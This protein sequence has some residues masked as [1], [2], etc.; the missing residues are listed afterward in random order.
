MRPLLFGLAAVAAVA[1]IASAADL[2]RKVPAYSPSVPVAFNW[3]GFYIGLNAGG[4]WGRDELTTSASVPNFGD[5][6][7][8]NWNAAAA[9]ANTPAGFIGGLELGY[10]WQ[11]NGVVLGLEG[12]VNGLTGK[13]T[14]AVV[15]PG[16]SPAAGDSFTTSAESNFLA[17]VRGRLGLALDRWLAYGTGGMAIGIV[18]TTDAALVDCGVACTPEAVSQTTTRIGWTAGGG[19]EYAFIP[20][21]TAKIEYLYVHLGDF[22]TAIP[23]LVA[24][25]DAGP[26]I[27]V[28]HK[29]TDNIVRVGANYKFW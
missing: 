5:I 29:W 20:S 23:C 26:D 28:A 6:G 8:A 17:T 25:A 11:I 3:T 12:D 16:P 24:C 4:H 7:A 9:G 2:V 18:K 15:F 1:Q 27:V 19:V 22:N 21:W 10:N 13:G 14:R